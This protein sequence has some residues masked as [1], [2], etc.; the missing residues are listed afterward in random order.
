M[1]CRCGGKY[2]VGRYGSAN[3]LKF[4]LPSCLDSDGI[5][6]QHHNTRRELLMRDEA[7]RIAAVFAKL[8]ELLGA[9]EE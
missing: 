7:Q 6:N 9:P 1:R 5:L 4:K 2:I 8:Q 3:A